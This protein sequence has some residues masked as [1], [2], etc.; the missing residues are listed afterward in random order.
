MGLQGHRDD[1]ARGF[2]SRR[3]SR[4][5]SNGCEL[6]AV[7]FSA[8]AAAGHLTNRVVLVE[9]DNITTKAYISHIRGRNRYLSAIAHRLLHVAHWNGI[10]L[11]AVHCPGGHQSTCQQARSMEVRLHRPQARPCSLPPGRPSLW[12]ALRRSLCQPAQH[13]AAPL[14]LMAS[15]ARSRSRRCALVPADRH[16]RMLL[17]ARGAHRYA[18]LCGHLLAHDDHPRRSFVAFAAVVAGLQLSSV[19]EPLILPAAS[20]TL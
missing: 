16:E 15:S 17:P 13:T 8:M 3:E 20:T 2:F 12:S 7:L 11:L 19:D 10:H 9:T 5:S 6:T 18:P 1:E 4:I 14:C